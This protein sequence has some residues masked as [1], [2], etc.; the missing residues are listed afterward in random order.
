MSYFRKMT[1]DGDSLAAVRKVDR[2]RRIIEIVGRKGFASVEELAASLDVTTQTIRRDLGELS[3]GGLLRRY[4][5]G[6]G[7]SGEVDTA[8]YRRRKE[9]QAEAKRRMGRCVAGMISDGATLFLDTGTTLEAVAEA[10]TARRGL[11]VVTYSLRVANYLS[12]RTDFV[13]WLPGG[14]VRNADGAVFGDGAAAFLRRFHLDVAVIGASGIDDQGM[15]S[16]DDFEEVALVRSAV[17]QART[18]I[19]AADATKFGRTGAVNLGPVADVA[20]LVTDA[21]PGLALCAILDAAHVRLHV[22]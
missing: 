17:A 8:N 6:A 22:L 12:E 10:L 20:A 4:H 9:E 19:L 1:G 18:V 13:L 15:M 7:L 11:K 21:R 14:Q 16:D 2:Q 5:G 3:G